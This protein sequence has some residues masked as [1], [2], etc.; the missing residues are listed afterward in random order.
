M[1]PACAVTALKPAS[2]RLSA[3]APAFDLELPDP[4]PACNDSSR[5][6]AIRGASVQAIPA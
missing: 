3:P 2:L 5:A 4:V 6:A 1:H